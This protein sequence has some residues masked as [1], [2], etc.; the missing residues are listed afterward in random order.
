MGTRR[1]RPVLE[2][3]ERRWWAG[4]HT[5]FAIL[6]H[7]FRF[8]SCDALGFPT[9]REKRRHGDEGVMVESS[10][11]R[12]LKNVLVSLLM[13]LPYARSMLRGAEKLVNVRSIQNVMSDASIMSDNGAKRAN[14]DGNPLSDSSEISLHYFPVRYFDGEFLQPRIAPGDQLTTSLSPPQPSS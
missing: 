12:R 13:S 3:H 1:Q 5:F 9:C 14:L 6:G 8:L 10:S 4:I 7:I 2:R 11:R